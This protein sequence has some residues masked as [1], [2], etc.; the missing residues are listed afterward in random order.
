LLIEA[1]AME[2]RVDGKLVELTRTQ[3]GILRFLASHVGFARE[4]ILDCLLSYKLRA[5]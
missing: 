1:D 2:V 5:V 3:F 4:K